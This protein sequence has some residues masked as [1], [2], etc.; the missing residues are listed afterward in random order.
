MSKASRK[1]EESREALRAVARRFIVEGG[2]LYDRN[3]VRV[4]P[5]IPPEP[6]PPAL[7]L[8]EGEKQ[9]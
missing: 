6:T 4:T 9:G 3:M 5:R 1:I 7:S 8:V 2:H